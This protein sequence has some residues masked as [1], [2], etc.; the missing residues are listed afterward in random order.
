MSPDTATSVAYSGDNGS[1][2]VSFACWKT[3]STLIGKPA[4]WA[5]TRMKSVRGCAPTLDRDLA[6]RGLGS[7][8]KDGQESQWYVVRDPLPAITAGPAA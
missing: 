8:H 4:P 1:A 5:L 2:H 6:R 3:G 7:Y